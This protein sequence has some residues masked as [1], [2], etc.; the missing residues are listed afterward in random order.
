MSEAARNG[1][2]RRKKERLVKASRMYAMCQKAK[3]KDPGFLVTL[4]LAAFEDMPLVEATGFVR[5]NRPNLEDMAWAFR[6]SGS[7][8]EF[9]A[10]LQQRIRDMK[11][12]SGGR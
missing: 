3:V 12:R 11:R 1:E 2:E 6:N 4:A 7:A 10:K 8:E 5:A 9:E